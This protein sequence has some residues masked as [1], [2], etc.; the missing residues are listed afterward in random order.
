MTQ[1]T[2][3]LPFLL[4][5]ILGSRP[6]ASPSVNALPIRYEPTPTLKRPCHASPV[7]EIDSGNGFVGSSVHCVHDDAL[8]YQ[9]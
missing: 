7:N 5:Q 6:W 3:G 4:D 9:P 1:S 2:G 8:T